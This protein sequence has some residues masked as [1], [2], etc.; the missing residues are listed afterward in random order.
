MTSHYLIQWCAEQDDKIRISL[1]WRHNER[2]GVS[3][4]QPHHC[5]LNRLFRSRSKKTSKLHVTGLCA[6]NSPLTG[7]FPAQMASNAEMFPFDDVIMLWSKA[8]EPTMTKKNWLFLEIRFRWQGDCPKWSRFNE[9][10]LNVDRRLCILFDKLSWSQL[11]DNFEQ[12]IFLCY[13]N[14]IQNSLCVSSIIST[15]QA[16]ISNR[17]VKC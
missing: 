1:Q 10:D 7:E 2:D 4:H 9:Q 16:T 15:N 3:T 14:N 5:L 12:N 11:N 13:L 17:N 6:G 8:L